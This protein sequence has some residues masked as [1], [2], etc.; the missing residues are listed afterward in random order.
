MT[1]NTYMKIAAAQITAHDDKKTNLES[2]LLYIK[3]TKSVDTLCFPELCLQSNVKQVT[4]IEKEIKILCAAAKQYQTN[5]I[6]GSYV[7]IDGKIK[8]RIFVI[9]KQW[10]VIHRYN[11]KHPYASEQ[12]SVSKGRN[13]KPFLLDGISCAV[14]NCRDYAFPEYSRDLAQKWAKIIFCPAYLMSFPRTKDVLE[15]IPQVRAFDCMSYFVMVDAIA[16][17]TFKRTK[18]CHPLYEIQK[19]TGKE[20]VICATLDVTEIDQLRIEFSNLKKRKSLDMVH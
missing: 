19:L 18:I 8:N 5:I 10:E 15:K 3:K 17:D 7:A 12:E 9:N 20:W 11:K 16:D 13:N 2:M 6:F 4:S 1:K 14:I